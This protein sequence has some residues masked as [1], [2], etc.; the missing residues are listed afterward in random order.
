MK[1][2]SYREACF[3]NAGLVFVPINE[4]PM[5]SRIYSGNNVVDVTYHNSWSGNQVFRLQR[6]QYI[7]TAPN[8]MEMI[9]AFNIL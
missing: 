8:G 2:I 1:L 6:W 5:V 4:R 9:I 7:D 3:A